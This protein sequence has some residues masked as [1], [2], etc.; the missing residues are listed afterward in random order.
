VAINSHGQGDDETPGFAPR[1]DFPMTPS[2]E[3]IFS[4]FA[5]DPEMAELIVQF[6]SELPDRVGSLMTNWHSQ[7]YPEVKRAAHQL[8]GAS[9]GYGFPAIGLAASRVESGLR[10]RSA[11]QITQ[12]A[13]RLIEDIR[14]LSDLCT[15]VSASRT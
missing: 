11:D 9:A 10:G 15:R 2:N 8:K 13:A 12:D 5:S 6:V 14:H 1:K 3:P 7:N 4:E